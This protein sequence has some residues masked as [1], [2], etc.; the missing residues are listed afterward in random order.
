MK[1]PICLVAILWVLGVFVSPASAKPKDKTL[2][3][4]PEKVYAA[5]QKVIRSHYVVTFADDKQMLVSFKTPQTNT[6]PMD[7]SAAVET[8]G[9]GSKLTINLQNTTGITYGKGGRIA[10]SIFKWVSE[11]L[12]RPAN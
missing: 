11:E 10:D 3:A 12:E 7:G 5:V 4:P 2:S 6:A 9:S 1:T 8:A